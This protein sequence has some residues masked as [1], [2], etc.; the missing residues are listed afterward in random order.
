MG[1]L[2]II[3]S[4]LSHS[5]H[6][7]WHLMLVHPES[8]IGRI[9]CQPRKIE[10]PYW[11]TDGRKGRVGYGSAKATILFIYFI[12]ILPLEDFFYMFNC[13]FLI[14][15]QLTDSLLEIEEERAIWSAIKEQAKSYNVQITSLST[16]LLEVRI[17]AQLFRK[18]VLVPLIVL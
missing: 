10:K 8:K 5:N 12:V 1:G 4:I 6:Q 7:I 14:L 18:P 17:M 9:W 2:T 15:Q 3:S 16:K 13:I 11:S